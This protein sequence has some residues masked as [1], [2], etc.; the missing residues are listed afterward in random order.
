MQKIKK[1]VERDRA[2]HAEL[3]GQFRSIGPAVLRAALL[4]TNK[5]RKTPA[6]SNAA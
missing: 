1:P 4:H 3:H 2:Q 6:A 5:K